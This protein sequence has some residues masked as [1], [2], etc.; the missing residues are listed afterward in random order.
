MEKWLIK[1]WGKRCPDYFEEC[2]LCEIWKAFDTIKEGVE[3]G[4]DDE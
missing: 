1:N 3:L 4:V 2:H